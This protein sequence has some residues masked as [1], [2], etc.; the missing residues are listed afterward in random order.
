MIM[1]L[2]KITALT[3]MTFILLSCIPDRTIRK[4]SL[5]GWDVI[6]NDRDKMLELCGGWTVGCADMKNKVI[7][8]DEWDFS[9]CGHELHHITHG[10]FH[11]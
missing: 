11:D 10:R 6:Y 1:K 9:V 2:L 8:C 3:L 4:F 5:D 7:Y